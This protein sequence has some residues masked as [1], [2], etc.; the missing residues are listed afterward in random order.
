MNVVAED[1]KGDF[2]KR[3]DN[4]V[5][6]KVCMNLT[7]DDLDIFLKQCIS[8]KNAIPQQYYPLLKEQFFQ[9]KLIKK[10]L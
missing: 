9:G 3:L 6:T 2:L 7:Y 5:P 4:F 8:D 10:L 1:S